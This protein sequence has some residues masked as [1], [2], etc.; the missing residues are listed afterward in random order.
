MKV[1]HSYPPNYE[2][3][4]QAIPDVKN[5]PTII[6][7][8]GDTLYIPSGATIDDHYMVHEEAHGAEQLQMGVDVWWEH[9][10]AEPRFRLEQELIA[11]RAQYK[12]LEA[13][14]PRHIRKATLVKISKD[15]S[16]AMYGKIVDKNK[17]RQLITGKEEL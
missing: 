12:D 13:N 3:I 17:A 10:L 8:Y 11:Y 7:A 5:T 15:L 4:I 6:F 16:G 14:Y 2:Q 9:Y 1:I